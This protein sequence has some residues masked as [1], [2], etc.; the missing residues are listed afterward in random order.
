MAT[1]KKKQPAKKEEHYQSFV[2]AKGPKPFVTFRLTQ[3]TVYWTV[4]GLLVLGLGTWAMYLT[5]KVQD[6]YNQVD[7]SHSMDTAPVHPSKR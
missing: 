7:A 1:K 5:V 3:Q 6:V 4:I 2:K